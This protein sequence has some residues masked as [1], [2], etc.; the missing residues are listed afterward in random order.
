MVLS[1]IF[2]LYELIKLE[3][4]CVYFV[5]GRQKK[6]FKAMA[7]I[8]AAWIANGQAKQACFTHMFDWEFETKR[9]CQMR[10]IYYRA[11]ELPHYHNIVL[12]ECIKVNKL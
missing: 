10:L 6:M 5:I 2:Q 7:L 4:S 11:K 12:G 8:C 3:H 9:E 1:H